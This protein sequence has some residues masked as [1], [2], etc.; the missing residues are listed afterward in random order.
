MDNLSPF[1]KDD[2]V[3][4]K[5]FLF[6]EE[7]SHLVTESQMTHFLKSILSADEMFI[8]ALA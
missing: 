4:V 1:E 2:L 8:V 6:G 7:R 5:A 3:P